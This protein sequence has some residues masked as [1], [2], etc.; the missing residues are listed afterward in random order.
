MNHT[1]NLFTEEDYK[2]YI[3]L[4]VYNLTMTLPYIC[5]VDEFQEVIYSKED[6]SKSDIRDI[7][8]SLS[9]KYKQDISNK[10]HLN[11]DRGGYFYRQSHIFLN[12]FYYID[13]ALSYFGAFS[14]YDK[15]ISNL[16][17]FK[18]VGEVASYYPLDDLIYKFDL[19]SPFSE[20]SIK[21]ISKVLRKELFKDE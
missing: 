12:P 1:S 5:L 3:F 4:K 14:I 18:N 10:G 15:C 19:P 21:R 17:F 13:Y 6:L 9:H 16:D 7:W 8:L 2:K 11:L 20:E